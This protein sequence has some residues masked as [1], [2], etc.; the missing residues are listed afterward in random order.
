MDRREI[1]VVHRQMEAYKGKGEALC[2]DEGF[3]FN[4]TNLFRQPLRAL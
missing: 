2:E 1:D 3:K 4:W